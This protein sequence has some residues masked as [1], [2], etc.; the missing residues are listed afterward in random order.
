MYEVGYGDQ[1]SNVFQISEHVYER[2]VWQPTVEYF[3]PC[4]WTT[5]A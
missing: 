5:C 1:R 4:R 2:N 3:L